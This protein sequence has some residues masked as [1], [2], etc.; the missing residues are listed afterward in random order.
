MENH[1]KNRKSS[2]QFQAPIVKSI[3]F[4]NPGPASSNTPTVGAGGS[5]PDGFQIGSTSQSKVAA[6]G[7]SPAVVQRASAAQ[8]AVS[9][10][11]IAGVLIT[12]T[13]STVFPSSGT[14]TANTIS[15]VAVTMTT[16]GFISNTGVDFLIVN[17]PT[18]QATLGI[19]GAVVSTTSTVLIQALNISNATNVT[20]TAGEAYLIANLRNLSSTVTISPPV[21]GVSTIQEVQVT[22]TGVAPGQL[23]AINKPAFQ[24]YVGV[25]GC[26][27]ISNNLIGVSFMN[28]S[29]A[30]VTPTASE[31]YQYVALSGLYANSNIMV[32]M[33]N[34]SGAPVTL[35]SCGLNTVT[36]TVTGLNVSTDFPLGINRSYYGYQNGAVTTYQPTGARVSAVNTLEVTYISAGAG[37]GF[38]AATGSVVT[39]ANYDVLAMPFVRQNAQAPLWVQSVT[40]TP[41]LVGALTT[42]E[43]TFAVSNITVSTVL[44]VNKPSFTSGIAVVG[45]RTVSTNVIGITYVNNTAA[46]ITPPAEAYVIGNFPN[47]LGVQHA[48]QQQVQTANVATVNLTNEVRNALTALGFIAGA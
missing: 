42:T 8:A 22:V 17:K 48:L 44:W 10:G 43:V 36:M 24:S 21:I 35:T 38:A 19:C 6:Y 16:Q 47:M 30:P 11:A 25:V 13:V 18:A 40:L 27:V 26:R 46:S 20:Q 29:S 32:G 2:R 4:V 39:P 15:S 37:A 23:L 33:I 1:M 31:A 45:C 9:Q 3:C 7:V 41:T 12:A 28:L 5:W 34:T 14:I